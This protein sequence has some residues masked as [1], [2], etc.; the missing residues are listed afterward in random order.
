LRIKIEKLCARVQQFGIRRD[1]QLAGPV[2]L[3]ELQAQVRTDPGRLA[4]SQDDS[5]D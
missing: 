3:G 2:A 1:D 5:G 4:R